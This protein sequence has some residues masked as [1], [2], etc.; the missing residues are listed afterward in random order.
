MKVTFLYLVVSA[1]GVHSMLAA[2]NAGPSARDWENPHV[3]G[4]GKEPGRA[5]YTPF[6]DEASALDEHRASTFI[7][8][9]D[10]M[11]KFHWVKRPELRPVD[12]YK[13]EF[14]VS[15]WKEIPVPSNW[16]M[17]GYGTP[18]YTNITYPFKRDYPRV[19]D[20]PDDHSWTAY[21]E[22][23]PVGS[24]RREFTLPAT[25]SG[26]QTY[27]AFNG[28]NSAFYV[29]INGQKVGYSQDSR[30][31][32]EFNISK[33]LKPGNNLIAVEVYRWCDGSYI[34]DQDFWR[35][36][37]IFRAVTLV[38]RTAMHLRDFQVQTPFDTAYE[39]STFKLHGTVQ[40][41]DSRITSASL[42]AKLL[43]ADGK[44][45]FATMRKLNVRAGGEAD[46]DIQ[47]PVKTPNKWS[48]ESPYLYK[49]ILTLKDSKGGTLEV[50]PC[51]VG[52][53][54]SEIK[55]NQI[56][57][58]GKKLMIKGVNRHEFDPDLGQVVTREMMIADIKLMKQHNI[59][60]DRTCHYP[61]VPEWYELADKFGLYIL[62]E[63]NVESHGYGSN[64]IQ[65][66]SD[67]EDYRD[68]IV[69]RLRRTI[70]RDK[71]HPSIIGFS[72][73]N[74]AG[75]GANFTAA[76]E[77][78]KSHHPEFFII[79]EPGNSIHGDALTPMYAKPQNIVDYYNR[80]GKGRPFFEIE[81]A[82]AM[83]NSTGNFQQYWDLFESEPWAHGG[84]I[85]DWVDQGIR[86]KAADG[87]EFW[88]YG[89]DFGDKPNDDNFNTNGLVLP[90]RTPHPGLAEV[91]KSYADIKVEPLDLLHGKIRIR[92]K[93]NFIDLGFIRATW[94][95]QE[96]GKTIQSGDVPLGSI[97]PGQ[98][99]EVALN[100]HQ[101]MLLPGAEYF[102]TVTFALA[103][104][105]A[106]APAG[107]IVTW[108]QFKVPF[109]VPPASN[110]K[111]DNLPAV[112][113]SEVPGEVVA[114]NDSFSIA[115]D[116][117]SGSIFSYNVGGRELLSA[118]LEPNYW[119][120]PTDND[121]GN[122]MPQRQ[123]IWQ[124]AS[125]H[126]VATSVKGEQP[127]PNVVK[128]TANAKL[129][130]G[131]AMQACVYT[132]YG[133]GSV[134]ID[135]VFEPGETPLPDLPRVGMQMRVIHAL[136]HVEWYGRGPQENYWDRNLGASVGIYKASVDNL[137]FPY[138]EP[139]ETGNRTDI[140]WVSFTDDQGFGL[141][142]TGMPQLS[143][144][145]WPFRMSE[146][147]HEKTPLNIGRKH[148]AEIL[149]SD[150]I[151]VNLD[152]RQMGVGGDDSWGAP[153]HKEFSLPATGYSYKF[154]LEPVGPR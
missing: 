73:G 43:D 87:K 147:E 56:L 29:W 51:S 13:P 21:D 15:S 108:D 112:T 99:G 46:L 115:I 65:P 136:R 123:G 18:I 121:R 105:T 107:H 134:E 116:A 130:A 149:P 78:A 66:I 11:W 144:S 8:S 35:M 81:Y 83:G 119:R 62:D 137:W 48:A 7:Q 91:K 49:L 68:A 93:Y 75:Y 61:N 27:L 71:N 76:K 92:N 79:Y 142:A 85:W 9:L 114:S 133:D 26:R 106:W 32:S 128:V 10:G 6:P 70:E 100:V 98:A 28:V 40:N 90:D 150:D 138:V 52:F 126:R 12:F 153:T 132:I 4:I 74:E 42:E 120:P 89:G 124:L 3:Y 101:P 154:L 72:M 5:T 125:I 33:Y 58:N 69:D 129:P 109:E 22:R 14:D 50:I 127:A 53:R 152:Y 95:L 139:Q 60:A 23:D 37:G 59:N 104:E 19:T 117:A 86:K 54:Q 145:A 47:Q 88:A 146:L 103:H 97:V 20:T 82:H 1:F 140:R 94:A 131:S 24:Y 151:T 113:L 102:L 31:T 77:W 55:G 16:E 57:F 110:R 39:N 63:A 84:F 122:H 80:F 141:K 135:S 17:Q 64:E 2:Q 45:V 143:F 44:P 148:S 30:M 34:E 25:W 96:N 118:P 41:L 36:S 67:G 38:S 111:T